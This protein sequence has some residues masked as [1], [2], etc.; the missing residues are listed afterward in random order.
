MLETD[1]YIL[2]GG[3]AGTLM[4]ILLYT[5]F[6]HDRYNRNIKW[7]IAFWVIAVMTFLFIAL[8][9]IISILAAGSIM[10]SAKEKYWD[11]IK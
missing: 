9:Y 11:R 7:K 5:D 1:L 6:F 8:I 10:T 2:L 4:S 3:V